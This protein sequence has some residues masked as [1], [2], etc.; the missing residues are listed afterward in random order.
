PPPAPRTAGRPPP[1]QRPPPRSRTPAPHQAGGT[2][3]GPWILPSPPAARRPAHPAPGPRPAP[4]RRRN[5]MCRSSCLGLHP[6]WA[7]LGSIQVSEDRPMKHPLAAALAVA[8]A[9][10]ASAPASAQDPQPAPVNADSAPQARSDNPLL[11]DSP[12]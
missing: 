12:L 2:S 5:T 4:A 7:T 1:R 3:L 9:A 6:P 10:V 11:V 8:L